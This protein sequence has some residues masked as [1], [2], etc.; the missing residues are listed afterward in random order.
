MDANNS[1]RII[2]KAIR[3]IAL[4]RSAKRVAMSPT[5][6]GGVGTARMTHGYVAKINDDPND[7]YC[8]TIDVGEY[9]GKRTKKIMH[10]LDN[11]HR[12]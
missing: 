3:K 12:L 8:G 4:G 5:G 6:V 2:K 9:Q 11:A 10:T 1:D 7:E